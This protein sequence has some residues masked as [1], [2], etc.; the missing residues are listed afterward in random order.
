M[1]LLFV[2][3]FLLAATSVCN[4]QLAAT[5]IS[6]NVTVD[7]SSDISPLFLDTN[8]FSN[9]R[10]ASLIATFL[11]G[12]S[13]APYTACHVWRSVT[14]L[15]ICR[16]PEQGE[17]S[18]S[19]MPISLTIT[20]DPTTKY[21]AGSALL[22]PVFFLG[23]AAVTA[24]ASLMFTKTR[25]ASW[26]RMLIHGRYPQHLL[27]V[28]FFLYQT[29]VSSATTVIALNPDLTSRILYAIPLAA[30][31]AAWVV[32]C[33]YLWKAIPQR[34]V[35]IRRFRD[36]SDEA[37]IEKELHRRLIQLEKENESAEAEATRLRLEAAQEEERLK[38][39]EDHGADAGSVKAEF[40]DATFVSESDALAM[41]NN[42]SLALPP[43]SPQH[44][45][46]LMPDGIV[47]YPG[48]L[49]ASVNSAGGVGSSLSSL[50]FGQN[51]FKSL[52]DLIPEGEEEMLMRHTEKYVAASLRADDAEKERLRRA[53]NLVYSKMLASQ[54]QAMAFDD[55]AVQL[56]MT[57]RDRWE[58]QKPLST[59]PE[60]IRMQTEAEEAD[61]E[62]VIALAKQAALAAYVPAPIADYLKAKN[63]VKSRTG[64]LLMWGGFFRHFK[65]STYWFAIVEFSLSLIAGV[66]EGWKPS[67]ASGS[68]CYVQSSIFLVANGTYFAMLVVLRPYVIPLE[69][70]LV[71]LSSFLQIIASCFTVVAVVSGNSWGN[72]GANV[73]AVACI[74][75]FVLKSLLDFFLVIAPLLYSLEAP[76]PTAKLTTYYFDTARETS[77]V[78]YYERRSR[79]F[80]NRRSSAKGEKSSGTAMRRLAIGA[81]KGD[82]DSTG[83][84]S[85][86]PRRSRA[87]SFSSV[88]GGG[89]PA[90]GQSV[91]GVAPTSPTSPNSR[92]PLAASS[93]AMFQSGGAAAADAN[94]NDSDGPP[95][96]Q[97]STRTGELQVRSVDDLENEALRYRVIGGR[98]NAYVGSRGVPEALHPFSMVPLP[99]ILPLPPRD[100]ENSNIR[101]R[102]AHLASLRVNK[103]DAVTAKFAE[104]FQGDFAS[105]VSSNANGGGSA[106]N[107][108]D[109][110]SSPTTRGL[111][112]PGLAG[113]AFLK[114]EHDKERAKEQRMSQT[115]LNVGQLNTLG[116]NKDRGS[117][118]SLKGSS[119]SKLYTSS[120]SDANSGN[121]KRGSNNVADDRRSGTSWG[122]TERHSSASRYQQHQDEDAAA[123]DPLLHEDDP[124]A[125]M[126]VLLFS[127]GAFHANRKAL[128]SSSTAAS[129]A[130][131]TIGQRSTDFSNSSF[132]SSP[133]SPLPPAAAVLPDNLHH[134][135]P[136]MSGDQK[137]DLVSQR[138][139]RMLQSSASLRPPPTVAA[140]Q[141]FQREAST[142]PPRSFRGAGVYAGTLPVTTGGEANGNYSFSPQ[143]R[144]AS[145]GRS[146]PR[147]VRFLGLQEDFVEL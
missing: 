54:I 139:L 31:I 118:G 16:Q 64:F 111:A 12:L 141:H 125:I 81:A 1:T 37:E 135:A 38:R 89:S 22:A 51:L 53:T 124:D 144:A 62:E 5:P 129:E 138:L 95:P 55:S 108:V 93:S 120:Q 44:S 58:D 71:M 2:L 122:G 119:S 74:Y 6:S 134:S 30:W 117:A 41:K 103:Q 75:L 92:R 140:P 11:S 128:T 52:R 146:S 36:V 105:E 17:L 109:R 57:G 79:M 68:S 90:D 65:E 13:G 4:A 26:R 76:W 47:R 147:R 46:I 101:L 84:V 66:L 43:P 102:N 60:A 83:S 32:P 7:S 8:P 24:V 10:S 34:A 19:Q 133:S 56:T 63:S 28:F 23:T 126:D 107:N 94:N 121:N 70:G 33:V 29:G 49:G 115:R 61:D 50:R 86:S 82:G 104:L 59:D 99:G 85:R 20:D 9:S 21:Y 114:E 91:S 145:G 127:R 100:P 48:E 110:V 72:V 78:A 96:Q 73:M 67:D 112:G 80:Q 142:T 15:T 137:R 116:N 27:F 131:P 143:Q 42:P 106:S 40:G 3:I 130:T 25:G 69:M 123:H 77:D 88:Q 113:L 136:H 97:L 35:F 39:I 98:R 132:G 18:V 87:G 45:G 14:L